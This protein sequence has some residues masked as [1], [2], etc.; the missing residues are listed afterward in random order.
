MATHDDR[1]VALRDILTRLCK[2]TGLSPE[3]LRHTEIDV[4]PLLALPAIA[5]HAQRTGVARE[6]AV[7]AVLRDVARQL[8]PSDLLIADAALSLGLLRDDLPPGLEADRLYAENLGDRRLYLATHWN[9]LHEVIDAGPAPGAPT[10]KRLRTVV[11]HQTFTALAGLLAVANGYPPPPARPLGAGATVTVVG[12]AVIDHLYTVDAF[13]TENLPASGTFTGHPG[14]KGLNR[15]VAAAR[16]GLD[17]QLVA[18][19]GG[20]ENGRAILSLLSEEGV[21]RDLVKLVPFAPTLITAVVQTATGA[22]QLIGCHDERVQLTGEDLRSGALRAALAG[23]AVVVATFEPP[24]RV[25]EQ[26]LGAVAELDPRPQVV[27]CPT[28]RTPVPQSLYTHLG[29]VDF[30]AGTT[31]ELRAM[32]PEADAG[33]TADVARLLRGL[34]VGTVCALSDFHCRVFAD[35]GELLIDDFPPVLRS[36]PGAA[37]AFAAA[38]ARRLVDA[39]G[40]LDAEDYRWATAAMFTTQQLGAVTAALPTVAEVDRVVAL[41]AGLPRGD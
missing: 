38:L 19:I 29:A 22:A 30:L 16:L 34:G 5:R 4:T 41:F 9:A 40:P 2:Y 31:A 25:I 7:P 33:D 20:D 8:P 26:L 17:A 21:H 27:L 37:A 28:P 23:S 1:T 10:V 32:L 35:G 12:D 36:A 11:E 18:A 24:A 13:A 14:G 39:H 3:R 6:E 15:A